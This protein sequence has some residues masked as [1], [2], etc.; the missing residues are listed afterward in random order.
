MIGMMEE[1]KFAEKILIT[2]A[3][4][5]NGSAIIKEFER[6]QIPVTALVRNLSK[7]P[8]DKPKAFITYTEGDMLHPD[9]LSGA[10]DGVERVLLMSTATLQMAETQCVFIDACKA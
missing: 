3:A 9:T 6:Q 8:P 5:M 2:G 10:L 7:L 1:N 4:G